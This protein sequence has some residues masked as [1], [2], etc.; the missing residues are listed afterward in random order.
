MQALKF[1]NTD[2][3]VLASNASTIIMMGPVGVGKTTLALLKVI[4]FTNAHMA[5][6]NNVRRCV[7]R[8][9]R[10]SEPQLQAVFSAIKAL[11]PTTKFAGRLPWTSEAAVQNPDGTISEI[12]FIVDVLPDRK[13]N[14][15]EKMAGLPAN[16]FLVNEV[17]LYSSPYVLQKA[18]ERAGRAGDISTG[19]T[20]K[21]LVLA[22][23]NPPEDS[24]WLAD[25][26]ENPPGSHD[27]SIGLS[28]PFK[29]DFICWPE[30]LI[31]IEDED[32][33]EIVGFEKNPLAET[34][35]KKRVEGHE[36]WLRIAMLNIKNKAYI[37]QNILGR[38]GFRFDGKPVYGA[39]F[40]PKMI[41]KMEVNLSKMLYIAV[42]P[43]GFNPAAV[44]FQRNSVTG[45]IGILHEFPTPVPGSTI[46][47]ELLE[48][49]IE[50]WLDSVGI[51]RQMR[52]KV[53]FFFDPS[54]HRS[55]AKV[56][57][58][59]EA[60]KK[61]FMSQLAG[62]AEAIKFAPRM[63][64]VKWH[65]YNDLFF[66]D[67]RCEKTIA[68][69]KT[70][71]YIPSGKREPAQNH[72]QGSACDLGAAIEY[73]CIPFRKISTGVVSAQHNARQKPAH[74]DD[75]IDEIVNMGQELVY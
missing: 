47:T 9:Y 57:P 52:R 15:D 17:Q 3:R 60:S 48:N 37:Y 54:N 16:V 46:F 59:L 12:E 36:Y 67:P 35:Y 64:A 51:T 29:T 6:V 4:Q 53:Q 74:R 70:D 28:N 39:H 13:E 40:K 23:C 30:A 65:M 25:W 1:D 71:Y 5:P 63:E 68:A 18:Q 19:N 72:T 7:C 26:K 75:D 42:D 34:T 56:T 43:S 45:E 41:R 27:S 14:I 8:I 20:G 32:S 49:C 21:S 2:H 24:H 33:G 69:L 73:A 44:A 66:V 11:L 38:F 50:P 55:G 10:Q 62:G 61:G 31:A 58:R 22:D